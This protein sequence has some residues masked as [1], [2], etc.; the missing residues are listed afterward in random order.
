MAR[1]LLQMRI[2]FSE[3]ER[4]A[5]V[6]RG[7]IGF[8][9]TN[10]VILIHRADTNSQVETQP[11]EIKGLEMMRKSWIAGATGIAVENIN[12]YEWE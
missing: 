2:T 3:N 4:M 11:G 1:H 12:V 5:G 7:D 10:G 8:Q 6:Y 9:R